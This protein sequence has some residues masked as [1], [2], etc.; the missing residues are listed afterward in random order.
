[1][2]RDHRVALGRYADQGGRLVR[3]GRTELDVTGPRTPVADLVGTPRPAM[4]V[5]NED[6]L[7]YA[8]IRLDPESLAAVLAGLP[9][10][11]SP[12]TR[13]VLWGGMWDICRD[14]ELPAA[15]YLDLVL[16]G[17]ATETDATAVRNLLGQAGTAVYSYAP[18]SGRAKLAETWTSGLADLL[19][20]APAG[21]DLQLA[22]V[23]TFAG[24]ANAG[25]SG[26]L[27]HRWW[28]GA[29]VPEGLVLDTDLRWLLVSNLSR[30]GLIG[31]AEIAAEQGRDPSVTGSEQGAGARAAQPTAT[32]KA[33]AWRLAVETDEV[34]NTVHQA[35]CLS[36]WM[37][38]QDDVLLPYIDRY[39]AAV[40]E[41]SALRGIW[42]DR[43][44]ALRKNVL[45]WLFPWPTDKQ[46]VL[47][48]LDRWL[49]QAGLSDAALRI[50]NE[51]RDDLVR[52]LRCQAGG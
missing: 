31:E 2:L 27:L 6:D 1:M 37:R 3:T 38:G 24:A 4:V 44:A 15:D 14:A 26:E 12:L 43:G 33:E 22:L 42:A 40:E 29:D 23:R 50:I 19:A 28:S 11:T 21:S 17:V 20:E 51:R 35:I 13:A 5:V 16:R 36:F 18:L 9:T 46:P 34:T 8:K 48:R 25:W 10:V 45:R 47:D 30:L 52:A 39:F 41:I 7:T 49:D 32:A